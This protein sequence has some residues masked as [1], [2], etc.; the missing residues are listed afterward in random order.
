MP[1]LSKFTV[2]NVREMVTTA[3]VGLLC[4]FLAA[5]TSV[6]TPAGPH[7]SLGTVQ[8]AIYGGVVDGTT[9][10]A[11]V[12]ILYPQT[13][14]GQAGKI[15]LATGVLISPKLVLTNR[16]TVSYM[17][18]PT[19]DCTT[20]GTTTNGAMFLGDVNPAAVRIFTNSSFNPSS[21]PVPAAVAMTFFYPP[22]A[23]QCNAN[24][25]IIVLDRPLMGITPLRIRATNPTVVGE[26]MDVVG[27]GVND[28][29]QPVGTRITRAG[30]AV[31]QVGPAVSPTGGI[32]GPNEF[33]L[34]KSV[35]GGDNG[36]PAISVLSGAVVGVSS[37]VR[38]LDCAVD[39]GKTFTAV[40][41]F[42]SG[43]IANAFSFVGAFPS[44]EPSVPVVV[45]AGSPPVDAAADAA[46]VFR[47]AAASP[48]DAGMRRDSDAALEPM[49]FPIPTDEGGSGCQMG[50]ANANRPQMV[51]VCGWALLALAAIAS[52]RRLSH[53]A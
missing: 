13:A 24:I 39:E 11:V 8:E 48:A 33:S 19:I 16:A 6:V 52:R 27:Y 32:T 38:V 51:D 10:P 36:G 14:F 17:K 7:E 53:A 34:G 15:G 44:L 28:I 41:P 43:F 2:K 45:D 42:V 1:S 12:S 46:V 37:R 40:G 35:C 3:H 30:I 4:G 31:Q 26:R 23:A 5:C 18:T 22:G 47:D 9:H 21:P 50:L 49:G 25:A 29:A 20:D